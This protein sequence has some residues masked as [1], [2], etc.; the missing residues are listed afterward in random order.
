MILIPIDVGALGT[1]PKGL[2]KV[3][4]NGNQWKNGDNVDQS[5]VKID[6][7]IETNSG[8]LRILRLILSLRYRFRPTR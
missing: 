6:E 8:D 1:V 3:G 4:G 2:E 5:N 7:N